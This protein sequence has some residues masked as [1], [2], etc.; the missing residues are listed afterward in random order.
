M[1]TSHIVQRHW[2]VYRLSGDTRVLWRFDGPD[3][4]DV[5][6]GLVR[7]FYVKTQWRVFGVW[8]TYNK[9]SSAFLEDAFRKIDEPGF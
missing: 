5:T 8:V 4:T 3:L 1:K 7:T 2:T 9:A 6:R